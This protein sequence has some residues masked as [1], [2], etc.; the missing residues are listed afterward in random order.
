VPIVND[1]VYS[2]IPPAGRLMLAA[3]ELSIRHPVGGEITFSV[4]PPFD[5]DPAGDITSEP[6]AAPRRR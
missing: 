4:D 2:D 1:P 6:P 5:L 3:V